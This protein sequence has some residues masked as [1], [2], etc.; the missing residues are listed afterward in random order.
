MEEL[1]SLMN[2]PAGR[3]TAILVMLELDEWAV[4]LAGNVFVRSSPA[5]QV[6]RATRAVAVPNVLNGLQPL[7]AENSGDFR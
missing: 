6:I 1:C 2:I 4:G 5:V 7:A 3:L